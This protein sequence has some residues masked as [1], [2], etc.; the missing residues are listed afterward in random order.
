MYR[1]P[2]CEN[3]PV[4]NFR[5]RYEVEVYCSCFS[6][7][8]DHDFISQ[9]EAETFSMRNP[10]FFFLLSQRRSGS[11]YRLSPSQ[12]RTETLTPSHWPHSLT[13]RKR[14]QCDRYGRVPNPEATNA[15]CVTPF[16][17]NKQT[18]AAKFRNCALRLM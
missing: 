7:I 6:S 1:R 11:H 14:K 9:H 17:K 15:R 18:P 10:P 3:V 8:F 16:C 13:T 4:Q 5:L 12:P 2:Q